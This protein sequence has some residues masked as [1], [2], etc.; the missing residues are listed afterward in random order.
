MGKRGCQRQKEQVW[1]YGNMEF[2]SGPFNFEVCASG[3]E[4]R[5]QFVICALVAP[6]LVD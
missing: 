1:G 4:S 3:I 6:L 5:Q 2:G